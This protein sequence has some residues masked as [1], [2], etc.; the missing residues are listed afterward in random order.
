MWHSVRRG[1]LWF[2]IILFALPLI[3]Y[4]PKAVGSRD[5]TATNATPSQEI[6]RLYVPLITTPSGVGLACEPRDEINGSNLR[7]Y[8][9]PDNRVEAYLATGDPYLE[10]GLSQ[11]DQYWSTIDPA[12]LRGYVDVMLPSTLRVLDHNAARAMMARFRT[13]LEGQRNAQTGLIPYSHFGEDNIGGVDRANRQTLRMVARMAEFAE[14]FPSDVNTL[15]TLRAMADATIEHFDYTEANGQPAGVTNWV[16]VDQPDDYAQSYLTQDLGYAA[17]GVAVAG[18]ATGDRR[19]L[20]WARQKI[21]FVWANRTNPPLPLIPEILTGTSWNITGEDSFTSDSDTLYFVQELFKL[22]ALT[23]D[24]V[25]K[26]RGL[27]VADWWYEHAWMPQYGHFSRKLNRSDGMMHKAD[28]YGDAKHNLLFAL[29]GAY[30]FSGDTKYLTRVKEAYRNLRAAGQDGF[31]PRT[32][33]EGQ[34]VVEDGP[35]RHQ[36]YYIELLVYAYEVSGDREFLTMAEEFAQHLL[37]KRPDLIRQASG[38]GGTAYL[39]LAM[40]RNEIER[41]EVDFQTCGA[42]VNHVVLKQNGVTVL[43]RMVAADVAVIYIPAG[44]YEVQI[45]KDARSSSQP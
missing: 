44:N 23:N 32:I 36:S 18:L 15:A 22:Y 33:F 9:R 39:R 34:M 24:P 16:R 11:I 21:D 26:D 28:L 7:T 12:L 30:Q 2:L 45:V 19:Y 27:A 41:L 43:D 1:L 5:S 35:D 3:T 31:I 17:Y 37:S 6:T 20:D 4:G 25:Y 40:A 13:Y 14:W 29:V 8:L 42:P 38:Q 10:Y